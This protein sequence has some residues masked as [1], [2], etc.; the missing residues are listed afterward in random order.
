MKYC[1]LDDK[2]QLDLTAHVISKKVKLN[3]HLQLKLPSLHGLWLQRQ[4]KNK[5]EKCTADRKVFKVLFT[6]RIMSIKA[7]HSII[8]LMDVVVW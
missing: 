8:D 3:S 5:K 6:D 7:S 4:T 2:L 1:T